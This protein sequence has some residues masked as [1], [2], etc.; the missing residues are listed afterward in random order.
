MCPEPPG[1]LEALTANLGPLTDNHHDALAASTAHGR[2]SE[3]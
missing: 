3:L 1:N 2:L